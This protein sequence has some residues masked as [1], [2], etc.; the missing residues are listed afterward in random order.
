[1]F[2]GISIIRQK[3]VIIGYADRVMCL[4]IGRSDPWRKIH[5]LPFLLVFSSHFSYATLLI[6]A[7]VSVNFPGKF[8][9]S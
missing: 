9:H 6:K 5:K 2:A 7:S 4:V 3:S 1:M 8:K